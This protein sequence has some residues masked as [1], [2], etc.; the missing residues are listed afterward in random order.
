MASDEAIRHDCGID[1]FLFLRYIEFLLL[2][3]GP[4]A[5]VVLPVL[6][7]MNVIGGEGVRGGTSDYRRR[8]ICG[9]IFVV[10]C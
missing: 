3:F 9:A 2:L 8:L 7:S 10:R 1:A 4:L 6:L 5:L